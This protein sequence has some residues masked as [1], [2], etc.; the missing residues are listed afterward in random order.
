VEVGCQPTRVD[1]ERLLVLVIRP[2]VRW[3]DADELIDPIPPTSRIH[4]SMLG[5]NSL[6]L[7][8]PKQRGVRR[9]CE[10]VESTQK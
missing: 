10:G 5:L 9:G 4:Q 3:A 1:V 7:L 2:N 6:G 8:S